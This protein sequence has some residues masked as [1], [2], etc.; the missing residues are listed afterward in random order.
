MKTIIVATDFSQAAMNAANYAAQMAIAVEA[1][2]LLLHVYQVPV[3]YLEVPE[4]ITELSIMENAEKE[5][6][7]VKALL[8]TN[9]GGKINIVTEVI[10]GTF[11]P[12]LSM[13]CDRIKPYSA[14]MGS[15][16]K[17]VAEHLLF[18]HH[19]VYAIKHLKWP[20]ITVPARA[21]YSSIKK[22]ALACDF[23]KVATHIPVDEIKML[24]TNFNAE[25]YVLNIAKEN[26]FDPEIVFESGLLEELLAPVKPQYRFITGNNT[27]DG[28][29]EFAEK[30]EVDLLLVLPKRHGL[31][32]QLLHR[33]HSKQI[34]LR[35][36]VPVMALHA[37]Y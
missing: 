22:I 1:D 12:E 33:S 15:Q 19:A 18:G 8:S 30:N 20:L 13:V 37:E 7:G 16:G 2:L 24:V 34:V 27:D 23:H 14:V 9:T 21:I 32:D 35:S 3:P 4:A 6:T 11:F 5:L 36:P 17:T 25:L 29:I 31:I 28:I 26:M 10:M